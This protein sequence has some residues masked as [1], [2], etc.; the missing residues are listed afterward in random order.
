MSQIGSPTGGLT[1][2]VERLKQGSAVVHQWKLVVDDF[3]AN[4]LCSVSGTLN[5]PMK[6]KYMILVL[7]I[8]LEEMNAWQWQECCDGAVK[9]LNQIE[10]YKYIT[11]DN[12]IMNWRYAFHE[13]N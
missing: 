13:N 10:K 8:T 3:D 1:P 5:I 12:T 9:Q 6:C 7:Y 11:S 2:R 4:E